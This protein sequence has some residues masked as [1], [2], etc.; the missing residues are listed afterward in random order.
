ML[1]V[2]ANGFGLLRHE[3]ITRISIA[4]AIAIFADYYRGLSRPEVR[5]LRRS[6]GQN[7]AGRLGN[8]RL[9]AFGSASALPV[10]FDS[11]RGSSRQE[12]KGCWPRG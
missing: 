12:G 9:L 8:M 1:L 10:P 7:Q 11:D 4:F 2:Y 6:A 5:G 3:S